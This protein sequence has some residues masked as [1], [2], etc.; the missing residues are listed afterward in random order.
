MITD[1][2]TQ[3]AA[4]QKGE[5]D[6]LTHCSLS[7]KATVEGDSNLVWQ[8]TLFRGNNWLSFC[9]NKAPFDN[10]LARKAAQYA[11]DKDAVLVGG[12]EG[13]GAFLPAFPTLRKTPMNSPTAM[14]RRRQRSIW[15]SIRQKPE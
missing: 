7:A 5:I 3:I 13:L 12:S 15:N 2:T 9:Q 11:I 1:P 8:E 10:I 6:F 14:T 4:L